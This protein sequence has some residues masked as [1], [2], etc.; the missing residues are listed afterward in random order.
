[1]AKS[2]GKKESKMVNKIRR[3]VS[4]EFVPPSPS[5]WRVNFERRKEEN[6]LEMVVVVV[7]V[8]VMESD[9]EEEEDIALLAV[10]PF[11]S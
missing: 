3:S 4:N 11:F 5:R 6:A 10:T 7:V 1:M 9:E 8:M 2:V